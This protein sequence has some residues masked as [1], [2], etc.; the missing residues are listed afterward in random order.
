MF[1]IVLLVFHPMLAATSVY[2]LVTSRQFR[3]HGQGHC[4]HIWGIHKLKKREKN[5]NVAML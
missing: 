4:V 1:V 3:R 2:E 5:S